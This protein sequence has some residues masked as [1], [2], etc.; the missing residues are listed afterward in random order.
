MPTIYG[1]NPI[2]ELLA[3]DKTINKIYIQKGVKDLYDIKNE[4]L[5]KKVI[6]VDSDKYK[7][8]KLSGNGV[9]QGIVASYTEYKYYDVED[10]IEHAKKRKEAP[11]I[12]ILD[13]IEDPQNLGAIIRTSEC[14]GAHGVIIAKRNAVAIN[15]T[16]E[17]VAAGACSYM[18]VARVANI[19][20][21]IKKLKEKGLWIYALDMDGET[22]IYNYD[23]KGG[24]GIV[25]GNEGNGVSRLVK[26]NCD[27]I[28]KIPMKGNINSLNASAS[29]AMVSYEIFRQN[30]M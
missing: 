28:L 8:D 3:S 2:K 30:N 6:V 21:T 24:V 10:I 1:R 27:V 7:L 26:E 16:V 20:E 15:D 25:I 22:E 13:K 12:V 5:E 18:K 29:L 14:M 4:A 23:L 9:H 17:K 11:F 19:T